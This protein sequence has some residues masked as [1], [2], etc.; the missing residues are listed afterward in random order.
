MRKIVTVLGLV[1]CVGAVFAEEAD[2]STGRDRNHYSLDR[3]V[4]LQ[5]MR[6]ELTFSEEDLRAR[7]AQGRVEFD[8]RARGQ[9]LKTLR[10]DALDMAILGVQIDGDSVAWA[11]DDAVLSVPLPQPLVR[12]E[13]TKVVVQYRIEDPPEGMYFVLPSTAEPHRPLMVYTLSEALWTRYW[14]PCHDWPNERWTSEMEITV[15]ATM[16]AVAN[17]V[18]ATEEP[19]AGEGTTAFT[20]RNDVPTAPHHI[21]IVIGE[22]VEIKSADGDLPLSIYTQKGREAAA[23]HT[24]RNV[25]RMIDFYDELL[26]VPFPYP[27]Y[28]HITVVDHVHG[29]MEQAGFSV[30]DPLRLTTGPDGQVPEDGIERYLTAHMLAHQWFGGIVNYRSVS[31]MWLNEGFATYLDH[32]WVGQRQGAGAFDALMWKSAQRTAAADDSQ[33]GLPLVHRAL[34]D[35]NDIFEFDDGKVYDK[36]AWILHML[37]LRLGEEIFWEGVRAY[38][39]TH[40]WQGVETSDLRQAFEE[41][42]GLDLEQFF[43][44]WVYR[45]GVPRLQ[46]EYA[47]NSE[48]SQ[49]SL[50]VTQSQL[51]D[52]EVPAFATPL[53]ILFDLGGE[54]AQFTVQLNERHHEF[55]WDLQV[56][57]EYVAIDPRGALLKTLDIDAPRNM[58]IVLAR[59][60]PTAG[61]RLDGIEALGAIVHVE[62]ER[63]LVEILGDTTQIRAVRET[64]AAG[65]GDRQT[66]GALEGLLETLDT[67]DPVVRAAVIQGIA[68]YPG[69]ERA[70]QVLL[71]DIDRGDV[72]V[73]GA[74]AWALGR[75][76]GGADLVERSE[77]GLQRMAESRS[78]YFVRQRALWAIDCERRPGLYDFLLRLAKKEGDPLRGLALENLGACGR[79]SQ[80]RDAVHARLLKVVY[81]DDRRLQYS[82]VQGLGAS[83]DPRAV[84]HLRRLA[85]SALGAG[86]QRAAQRALDRIRNAPEVDNSP[87]ALIELLESLEE[88][89]GQLQESYDEL[90]KRIENLEAAAQ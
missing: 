68:A 88:K 72:R 29:G 39:Q 25:P 70:H 33:T 90:K 3:P 23:R 52:D 50:T 18:L 21:G 13:S 65:L 31:Q 26:D 86:L 22:L 61:A 66:T 28:S 62:A 20:W 54:E 42:S 12:G 81:D 85:D 35:P 77:R 15:P 9:G 48:R 32:H 2:I 45:R 60:G 75:M 24:F 56:E 43:Q 57:P 49:A 36:G 67:P 87:L 64:A 55:S 6:L 8:L 19:G 1:V 37:R 73:E 76:R 53:D 34:E 14:I 51:I 69:S 10:L 46:V 59:S 89:N 16:T 80:R 58:L 7:R 71:G 63:A 40:R 30:V 83:R 38:L 41:V 74:L 79:L 47:W 78:R 84:P 5:H 44:Q 17:G 11:Y 27:S 82:A 4:D